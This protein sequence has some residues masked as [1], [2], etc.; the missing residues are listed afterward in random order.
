MW[1]FIKCI[2]WKFK[3]GI[4][5]G[6]HESRSDDEKIDNWYYELE[7][8]YAMDA[9]EPTLIIGDF[10]AHIGNKL[11]GIPG[12]ISKVNKNGEDLKV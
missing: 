12:N 6:L 9:D 7:E 3:I 2:E 8:H 5:R 10:N 4:V 11:D 1:V